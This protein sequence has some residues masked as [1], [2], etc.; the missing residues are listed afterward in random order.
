MPPTG[1]TDTVIVRQSGRPRFNLVRQI[2]ASLDR[3]L[4]PAIRKSASLPI[5]LQLRGK[6]EP[7]AGLQ[8]LYQR[9]L[10]KAQA[11]AARQ[12]FSIQLQTHRML[13][14]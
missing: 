14:T 9:Q 13:P 7:G 8:P 4:G 2:L 11:P 5:E 10:V 1:A 12:L 3:N 6:A